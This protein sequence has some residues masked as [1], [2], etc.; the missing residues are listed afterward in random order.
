VEIFMD[1]NSVAGLL[2]IKKGR[3]LLE[4]YGLGL[5]PGERWSTMSTVKSMTA[6]G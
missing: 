5:Q 4:R 3:V 2:V 6:A 1:R